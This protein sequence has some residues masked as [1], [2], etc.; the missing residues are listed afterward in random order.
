MEAREL[1]WCEDG[2]SE[3]RDKI[4]IVAQGEDTIYLRR[5]LRSW[6]AVYVRT[7]RSIENQLGVL[8]VFTCMDAAL[9]GHTSTVP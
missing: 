5:S 7:D 4:H 3:Y 8:S 6:S 9:P 2:P 1:V